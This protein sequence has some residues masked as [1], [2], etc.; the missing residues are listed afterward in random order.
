MTRHLIEIQ[1]EPV[2]VG[3]SWAPEGEIC[4][5]VEHGTCTSVEL[6]EV[7]DMSLGDTCVLCCCR[8]CERCD[9][10]IDL[11]CENNV[12]DAHGGYV[13]ICDTCLTDDDVL[14]DDDL[15]ADRR[16]EMAWASKLE[17]EVDTKVV[18]PRP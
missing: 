9:K 1:L 14:N 5:N 8:E 2:S 11:D 18:V 10:R 7:P 16:S 3:P 6:G 17:G 4:T 12:K 13:D 15:E